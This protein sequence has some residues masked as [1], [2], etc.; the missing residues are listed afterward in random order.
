MIIVTLDENNE[1]VLTPHA[2]AIAEFRK[3]YERTPA[4]QL[5]SA[6][7]IIYYMYSYDSKFRRTISDHRERLR[8]VKKFVHKGNDIAIS[9]YMKEAMQVFESLYDETSMSAYFVLFDNLQKLK[10]YARS[11]LLRLPVDWT[12]DADLYKDEID[13]AILVDYKEFSSINE[14]IPKTEALLKEFEL[15]LKD[16]VLANIAAFG[17][18]DIGYYET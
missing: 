12:K 5:P 2:L 4:D 16:E 3:L 6:F 15:K 1:I 17:G 7:G 14:Q 10:E 13:S 18:G 11:M 8:E 9:R